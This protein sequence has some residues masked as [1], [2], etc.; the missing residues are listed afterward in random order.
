MVSIIFVFSDRRGLDWVLFLL[1]NSGLRQ[2]TSGKS[3]DVNLHSHDVGSPEPG[4]SHTHT[5]FYIYIYIHI[6]YLYILYIY[7]VNISELETILHLLRLQQSYCQHF[8]GKPLKFRSLRSMSQLMLTCGGCTR[9]WKVAKGVL[10][11]PVLYNNAATTKH[12]SHS[13]AEHSLL[14]GFSG[15]SLAYKAKI[16]PS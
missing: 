15:C 16:R 10:S 8:L 5:Y 7:M 9:M 14:A 3:I 13:T 6:P 4:L 1:V 12:D 2:Y 11:K